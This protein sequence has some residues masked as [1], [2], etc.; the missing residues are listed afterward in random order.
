MTS[1][2]G[3]HEYLLPRGQNA[4]QPRY[5]KR[6]DDRTERTA[7]RTEAVGRRALPLLE[8]QRHGHDLTG[9]YCRLGQTQHAA[10]YGKLNDILRQSAADTC[11]RPRHDTG[12]HDPLRTEAVDKYAGNGIHDGIA[13]QKYVY[14]PRISV[15]VDAELGQD[16]GFEHRQQLPVEIVADNGYEYRRHDDPPSAPRVGYEF[17][18]QL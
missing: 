14:D 7:S 13:Y 6:S 17:H 3:H 16:L 11:Q 12:H 1:S 4:A 18:H 10:A 2:T 8:P 15:V 9:E 5:E